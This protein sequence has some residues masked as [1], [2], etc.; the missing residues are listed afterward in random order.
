MTED[1]IDRSIAIVGIGSFFPGATDTRQFWYNIIGGKDLFTDIP[2]DHWLIKDYYNQTP[3]DDIKVYANR[4]AFIPKID[5]DPLEY[6]IPPKTLSSI[7]SVQLLSLITAKQTID[8]VVSLR[9]NKIDRKNVSVILGV[10]SST[11]MVGHMSGKLQ[12]PHWIKAMRDSGV[13]EEKIGEI[14]ARIIDSYPEWTENTFPGLLG[15]VVAGRIAN[16]FN[17]GGTNCVVDAACASSLGAISMAVKELHIGESDLVLTG[18]C[19]ALNDIFMF[20]C[21]SKTGALSHS[22]DCRPF[23]DDADGTMLGEG[24]GMLALRR[25]ADAERDGDKIYAVI[26]GIGSSSDGKAKSVY[27]PR[28]EGQALALE[29]AYKAASVKPQEIDLIEAHGTATI[30]GDIAEISG[31]R[32]IFEDDNQNSNQVCALGSIKSQI[33]HTK[34]AAGTASIIKTVLALHHKVLPPTIKVNQPNPKLKLE[35]SPFYLNTR[36]RP[37]IRNTSIPRR[38]G[39]SSFGFGGSN[40]HVVLEEYRTAAHKALRFSQSPVHLILIHGNDDSELEN[41]LDVVLQQSKVSQLD[42][43]ACNYQKSFDG[44]NN[45][46]VAFI[47]NNQTELR[48][49]IDKVKGH[50][51]SNPSKAFSVPGKFYYQN[52]KHATPKI[53]FLFPGQGSQYLNMGSDII[54]EFENAMEIWDNAVSC[55][56]D[57]VDQ[58]SEI[59]FPI[60]TYSDND[61]IKQRKHL[62]ETQRAQPAL[63]ITC[64]AYL[65][66]LDL[67]E[68]KPH[69][70]GGHSYG[71][72]PALFA[73]GIIQSVHDLLYL[74]QKRGEFMGLNDIPA[75]AMTAVT[76][77]ESVMNKILK[78]NKSSVCVA[79]INSKTQIVISGK[80]EDIECIE[81]C[82]SEKSIPYKRLQVSSAFHSTLMQSSKSSFQK[83]LKSIKI[84]KPKIPVYSNKNGTTFPPRINEIKE[85]LASQLTNPVRFDDQINSMIQDGINIFIEV[86]PNSVLTN[87]LKN[88]IADKSDYLT[89]SMDTK[90]KNGLESLWNSFAQLSLAGINI[91]YENLWNNFVFESS[92]EPSKKQSKSSITVSLTGTNY[93]K[94]YPFQNSDTEAKTQPIVKCDTNDDELNSSKNNFA[95]VLSDIPREKTTDWYQSFY[96][97]QKQT[98]DAQKEF[99]QSLTDSHLAYLKVTEEAL[100]QLGGVQSSPT[101][102]PLTIDSESIQT[103]QTDQIDNQKPIKTR[104]IENIPQ[105]TDNHSAHEYDKESVGKILLEIVADKTGYPVDMIKL[106]M[107]LEADLGIDSIKRVEILSSLQER[108]PGL[109]ASDTSKLTAIKTLNEVISITHEDLASN[110]ISNHKSSEEKNSRHQSID[111]STLEELILDIVSEKTGYP[112][113]M[114]SIDMELEADLGIDSIKRVEILSALQEE[115][116]SINQLDTSKLASLTTL[117]DIISHV[118]TDGELDM[119]DISSETDLPPNDPLPSPDSISTY[120]LGVQ[121]SPAPGLAAIGIEKSDPLYIIKDNRG[122][123]RKLATKLKAKDIKVKVVEELPDDA[124]AVVFLKGINKSAGNLKYSDAILSNSEAFAISKKL[125]KNTT[126]GNRIFITVQDTNGDFGLSGQLN[127]ANVCS[128]GLSALSKTVAKEWPDAYVKAIDIQCINQSASEISNRLFFELVNGGPEIEIG[129][130]A[131]GQRLRIVSNRVKSNQHQPGFK[132]DDVVIVTGGGRGVTAA[133]ILE[134][135]KKIP[136]KIAVVGRT[137]I[138]KSSDQF[139]EVYSKTE[140]RQKIITESLQSNDKKTPAE[141]DRDV[142]KICINQEI[143]QTIRTCREAGS[144]VQYFACDINNFDS[145][146]KTVGKVKEQW[147]KI[148]GVIHGAGIIADQLIQTKTI[149]Q[150]ESVFKTKVDGLSNLISACENENISHIYVFSSIA[151]R[152]GN[153]GQV[154]YAMANEV[155]NKICQRESYVRGDSCSVKSFIWGPWDGGMVTPSLKTHFESFGIPLIP[156]KIGSEIFSQNLIKNGSANAELIIGGNPINKSPKNNHIWDICID[157]EFYPYLSNHKINDIPVVPMLVVNEWCLRTAKS[158]YPELYIKSCKNMKVLKGISLIEFTKKT[159]WHQLQCNIDSNNDMPVLNFL[160]TSQ[161]NTKYYEVTIEMTSDLLAPPAH[162]F[163]DTLSGNWTDNIDSI[164]QRK[165]FHEGDF[166]VI[167]KLGCFSDNG[168]TGLLKHVNGGLDKQKASWS[169]DV[170]ILDGGLQLALLW[171]LAMSNKTSLPTGFDQL[172]LYQPSIYEGSINCRCLS[173]KVSPLQTNWDI[174]FENKDGKALARINGLQMHVVPSGILLENS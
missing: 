147:G 125:S 40:F 32:R 140:I 173:E 42:N 114:I 157:K 44:K 156:L 126:Q 9:E 104:L 59:V 101:P 103:N 56:I 107:E 46:R 110:T 57:N 20:M 12:K 134:L 112:K 62:N 51:N 162:S 102:P 75:G 70:T 160:L 142:E 68:I 98:A 81:T 117:G 93:G 27:A 7:D 69:C 153:P 26:K 136:L 60:P 174:L 87:L 79:N 159:A 55:E 52:E 37:W 61:K 122:V 164:Y 1:R 76:T 58:L 94:K 63:G 50:I 97:I 19:D 14:S 128:S 146:S 135:A 74:S 11:E 127:V 3:G 45:F 137:K 36:K 4:G 90:G 83:C 25:L 41:R 6:G 138:K 89:V 106:D 151:S 116:S 78:T 150:F 84:A 24:I 53:A 80:I 67:V 118:K 29:R 39:V 111:T 10:A 48:T 23:S 71:E 139:S 144:D 120:E 121:A 8:D 72:I 161:N 54:S 158:L 152:E 77:S 22:G 47:I 105:Q 13:S 43:L 131:N 73:G 88:G 145:V 165:L 148:D 2:K 95:P 141:L 100:R 115:Y 17:F 18:G 109:D 123:A 124:R 167:N 113:D 170:A 149:R 82:L 28:P 21:F 31:L 85:D 92:N 15:N 65:S 166:R 66:I 91:N 143:H 30:A 163:N 133:C 171:K 38:A 130:P 86:G 129:L 172:V 108:I 34:A 132:K 96:N 168:C 99:Q 49:Y 35:Q 155:L 16:R 64:L 154:D 33:G 119:Q 169:S 5:F